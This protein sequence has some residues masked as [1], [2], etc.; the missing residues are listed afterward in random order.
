MLLW[1]TEVTYELQINVVKS[2]R[3]IRVLNQLLEITFHIQFLSVPIQL[4]S[5][6]TMDNARTET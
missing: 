2:K 5:S 4:I 3:H 6:T 1:S